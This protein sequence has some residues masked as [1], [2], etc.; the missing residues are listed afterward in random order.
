M[1]KVVLHHGKQ[2]PRNFS[3]SFDEQTI[4]ISIIEKQ[5]ANIWLIQEQ[6]SL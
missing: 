3:V 1:E 6:S 5:S 2:Q 4:Q